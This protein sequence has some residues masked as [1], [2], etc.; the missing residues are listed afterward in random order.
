MKA[1]AHRPKK[2]MITAETII[3]RILIIFIS[4][5]LC[6]YSIAWLLGF[7]KIY[8]EVILKLFLISS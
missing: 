4:F 3:P 6:I 2:P 1:T 5:I 8:F 7:V